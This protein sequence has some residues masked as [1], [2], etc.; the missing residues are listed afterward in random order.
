MKIVGH[1]LDGLVVMQVLSGLRL[2]S[3]SKRMFSFSSTTN[4]PISV[5]KDLILYNHNA[6][7]SVGLFHS[8]LLARP[9]LSLHRGPEINPH[10]N[11]SFST[12]ASPDNQVPPQPQPSSTF[13][14][15][16]KFPFSFSSVYKCVNI[17]TST[18]V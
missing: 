13:D 6:R 8:S 16:T 15:C 10:E 14:V 3:Y 12:N 5:M 7:V 11:R 2:P 4:S 18:Y 9:S 1:I 17:Y